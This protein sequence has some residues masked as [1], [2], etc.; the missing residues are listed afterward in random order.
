MR[1]QRC[2]ATSTAWPIMHA[3]AAVLTIQ[4][5]LR[6][7]QVN[8]RVF[9]RTA[10]RR[11]REART[12]AAAQAEAERD[13]AERAAIEEKQRHERASFAAIKVSCVPAVLHGMNSLH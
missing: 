1:R 2:G 3:L 8:R 7:W 4:I 11:S 13:A 10:E 6:R 5:A 9:A 12:A